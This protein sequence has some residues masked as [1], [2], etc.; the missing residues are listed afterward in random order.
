[1]K[2]AITGST[3]CIGRETVVEA[4]RQGHDVIAL[5]RSDDVSFETRS[6]RLEIRVC[7][8]NDETAVRKALKDCDCVIHLAADLKSRQQRSNT[9]DMTKNLLEAIEHEN[10]RQ[11]VL[12]SSISVLNYSNEAAMSTIDESTGRCEN[13]ALLGQY[14][15]MKCE[16][17]RMA[18]SWF[19]NHNSL[20]IIRPGLVYNETDLSG[21][22]AGFFKSG[23]G[24]AAMHDGQV[25]LV[26]LESV[27]RACIEACNKSTNSGLSVYHLTD[28]CL[29]RQKNY[30]KALKSAKVIRAYVPLPWKLYGLGAQIIRIVFES[31]G[32]RSR[33]PDAFCKNSVAARCKPFLFSNTKSCDAL[34]WAPRQTQL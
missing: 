29:P 18:E 26:Y 32:I 23:F 11:L 25:P 34:D 30:L 5:T 21:A 1:M 6:S 3:G 20:T 28:N 2:I 9:I 4:L 16:Q 22:H 19:V 10:I 14:A 13:D 15:A 27:A 31:I 7:N 24:I 8:L 12:C 17:E 33:L